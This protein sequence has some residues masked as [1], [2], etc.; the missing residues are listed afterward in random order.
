M[1]EC[2][3]KPIGDGERKFTFTAGTRSGWLRRLSAESHP[4]AAEDGM[5]GLRG[6]RIGDLECPQ[7]AHSQFAQM[8]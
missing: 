6:E 3:G 2:I 8:H 1:F 4:G 7:P 5:H